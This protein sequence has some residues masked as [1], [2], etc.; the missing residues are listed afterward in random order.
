MLN[1]GLGLTRVRFTDYLAAS[2]GMI[3]GTFL[4]VYPLAVWSR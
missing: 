3:P 4:Y 2:V 1:Y